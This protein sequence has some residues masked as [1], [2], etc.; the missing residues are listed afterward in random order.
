[1][2]WQSLI[3]T[4]KLRRDLAIIKSSNHPKCQENLLIQPVI[5]RFEYFFVKCNFI[6]F[7]WFTSMSSTKP[8]KPTEEESEDPN[9]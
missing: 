9:S 5:L 4:G 2:Q 6:K 7:Y 3:A 8:H 1:M